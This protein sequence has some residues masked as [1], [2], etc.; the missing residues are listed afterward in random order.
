[1]SPVAKPKKKSSKK[2][3]LSVSPVSTTATAPVTAPVV[4]PPPAA[5]SSLPGGGLPISDATVTQCNS[6]LGGVSDLLG[7]VTQL[8]AADIKRSLKMR[9]GGAQVVTDLVALCNHHGITSVGPVTVTA[10]SAEIDRANALNSI[11][12]NLSAVQKELTDAAFSAES[13][14]WQY[15]TA[16]YTVLLRLALMNP[17]LAAGLQPVQEFFQTKRT[18][19]TMRTTAAARTVKAGQKALAKHP[20]LTITTPAP[21][22]AVNGSG[23]SAGSAPNGTTGT[24]GAAPVATPA[25]VVNGAA[26][27]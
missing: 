12:V 21:A 17:T 2:S 10:M 11:G 24:S 14:C 7:P 6:L 1:M 5:S 4:T 13:T 23:T 9:K 18:K 20:E 22:A 26:H 25:P 3:A 16:L 15:A 19:G 27:S 8:S